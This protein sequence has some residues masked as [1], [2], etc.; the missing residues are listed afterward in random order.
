MTLMQPKIYSVGGWD[1]VHYY[2]PAS[3]VCL[4]EGIMFQAGLS[5]KGSK[6]VDEVK[7]KRLM[8]KE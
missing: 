2:Q 7:S 8:D 4:P 6:G 1:N 3:T 5:I